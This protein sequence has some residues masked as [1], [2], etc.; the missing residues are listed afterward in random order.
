[1]QSLALAGRV[2]ADEDASVF[3]PRLGLEAAHAAVE[4][5]ATT[6]AIASRTMLLESE[7]QTFPL[8]LS[9]PL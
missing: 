7:L 5:P 6:Q 2:A 1:M 3:G 8:T 9:P 4:A